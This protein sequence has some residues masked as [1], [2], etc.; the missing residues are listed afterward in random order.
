MSRKRKT[1][2]WILGGLGTLLF[3]VLCLFLLAPRLINLEPVRQEI[4]T[5][6]SRELGGQ[7][8]YQSISLSFLPR[9]RVVVNQGR[10]FIPG[11][12]SGSLESLTLYPAVFP[13]LAGKV[14]ISS[15]R[16]IAPELRV[17]LT[18]RPDADKKEGGF[19]SL[20]GIKEKVI[21]FLASMVLRAPGLDIRVERGTL[22]LSI[23]NRAT[24]WFRDIRAHVGLPPENLDLDITCRSEFCE[25]I[26]INGRLDTQGLNGEGRIALTRLRPQSLTGPLFPEASVEI[27]ESQI[28]LS[29]DFKISGLKSLGAS[30]LASSPILTLRR[31]TNKLPI[32]GGYLRAS[33]DMDED[34]VAV[35]LNDLHLNDPPLKVTGKLFAD[36]KS[37]SANVELVGN[38]IDLHSTGD[39]ALAVGGHIPIIQEIFSIVRGGRLPR[40]ALNVHGSSPAQL[41]ELADTRITA[42]IAEGQIFVPGLDLDL[43][44]VSGEVVILNGILD[45]KGLEARLG[46]IQGSQGVLKLG[47][48][49]ENPPFHLDTVVKADLAEIPAILKPLVE[50]RSVA[51][52][53]DLIE[54]LKGNATARVV[55]GESIES[56]KAR[57]HVS[58]LDL[59]ARYKGVPYPLVVT[60]GQVS[61]KGNTL[62]TIDVQGK[63]GSSGFSH[64][65]ARLDLDGE[66]YMEV[67]SGEFDV[68]LDEI[69]P[70]VSSIKGVGHRLKDLKDVKGELALSLTR[71][72]G[73]VSDPMNWS[74]ETNGE[75]KRLSVNTV[76]LDG[77]AEMT[78]ARFDATE[79]GLSFQDARI[80]LADAAFN[81]SGTLN[82]YMKGL[83]KA[84]MRFSGDMRPGSLRRLSRIVHIPPQ[85]KL[86]SPVSISN[87]YLTWERDGTVAFSGMLD[88]KGG[89]RF[90]IDG[91][92]R[93]GNLEIKDLSIEG[94]NSNAVIR[95]GLNQKEVKLEFSGRLT[96]AALEPFLA[97]TGSPIGSISGGLQVHF[98]RGYPMNFFAK[99]GLQGTDIDLPWD[100]GAPLRIERISLNA[101]QDKLRLEPGVI[102]WGDSR[103]VL[104]GEV[105]IDGDEIR[106]DMD[107][108]TDGLDAEKLVGL[109][110]GEGEGGAGTKEKSSWNLPFRGE[111]RVKADYLRY[112]RFT[113]KP[114]HVNISFG[115]E[116]ISASIIKADLCGISV[117]GTLRASREGIRLDLRPNAT[118]KELVATVKCLSDEKVKMDG[119]FDFKADVTGEGTGDALTRSLKGSYEFVAM[120]G[121]IYQHKLLS[122]ILALLS[123]TEIF[124]GSL[125]DLGMGGLAYNS[126][127]VKGRLEGGKLLFEQIVMDGKTMDLAGNGDIDFLG[128][129]INLILLASILK[130]ADSIIRMIPLVRYVLDGTLI[131]IP[132]K[133]TGDLADP[134]VRYVPASAVGSGLLGIIERTLKL[135]VKVIEPV[136]PKDLD[137]LIAPQD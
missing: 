77:L 36:Q 129:K 125:P 43:R 82:G 54:D 4:L 73:K 31:G 23:E 68:S 75:V 86:R 102:R 66:P 85:L 38:D 109:I 105:G 84:E 78:G 72:K 103:I 122:K 79:E 124:M 56:L 17:V 120:D 132:L 15:V 49:G 64:L 3:L 130:T 57:I 95:F 19:P 69:Y 101:K 30:L 104:E 61:F 26:S 29:L 108:V 90:S 135:P 44:D 113:W 74:F 48:T 27:A 9:P 112:Q 34:K 111:L 118:K 87:A 7:V 63:L 1:A 12:A 46:K 134:D 116:G 92:Q 126:I 89:P 97:E 80:G 65:S 99:G 110:P 53:I 127:T 8:E 133:V 136:L 20:K 24:F 128:K 96:R 114:L 137:G 123:V 2:V 117:P 14:R 11:K 25:G 59:S 60:G 55:L 45:G 47:L 83:H 16:A 42:R 6:L 76:L 67:G 51:R 18:Q 35:S 40:I 98:Q 119:K 39:A 91:L 107:L 100:V 37:R 71:L 93:R 21:P 70:W 94:V 13:L 88:A 121:R 22:G 58:Q 131:S 106:L 52:E 33:L 5:A 32:R 50:N 28:D 10:L 115:A 41:G 81:V 62:S